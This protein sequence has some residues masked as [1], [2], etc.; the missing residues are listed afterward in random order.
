MLE[1]EKEFN[2]DK[3]KEYNGWYNCPILLMTE[4]DGKGKKLKQILCCSYI[5]SVSVNSKCIFPII[6]TYYSLQF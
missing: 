5:I 2:L 1:T 6:I 3:P 4:Y